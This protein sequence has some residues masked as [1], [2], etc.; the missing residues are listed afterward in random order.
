VLVLV[1]ALAL[2]G[3]AAYVLF[4]ARGPTARDAL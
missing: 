4:G 2:A 3:A 1:A